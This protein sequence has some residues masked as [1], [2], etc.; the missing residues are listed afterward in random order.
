[1]LGGGY[2]VNGSLASLVS[3]GMVTF[4]GPDATLTSYSATLTKS[5]LGSLLG[6]SITAFAICRPPE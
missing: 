4:A 1:L 3:D 2:Q 5:L 6:A